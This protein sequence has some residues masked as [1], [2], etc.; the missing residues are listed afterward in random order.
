MCPHYVKLKKIFGPQSDDNHDFEA[1]SV[2]KSET[3][4]YLDDSQTEHVSVEDFEFDDDDSTNQ[5]TSDTE[6]SNTLVAPVS[7]TS[8]RKTNHT[9]TDSKS[10]NSKYSYS[11]YELMAR[12]RTNLAKS[13]LEFDRWRTEQEL[14]LRKEELAVRREELHIKKMEIEKDERVAMYEIEMKYKNKE[15]K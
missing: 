14:E 3:P 4:D 6:E 15:T 8:R 1:V 12:E 10:G 2:T 11:H 9:A 5:L 13:R 7:S